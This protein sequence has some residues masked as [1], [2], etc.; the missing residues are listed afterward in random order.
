LFT[1][2]IELTNLKEH[3]TIE[4][5]RKIVGIKASINKGLT[6]ELKTAFPGIVPVSR[7]EVKQAENINPN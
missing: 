2:L 4:G 3:L 1:K 6:E 5:L 7:S